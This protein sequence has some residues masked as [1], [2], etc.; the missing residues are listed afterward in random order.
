MLK[1]SG[2]QQWPGINAIDHRAGLLCS[3]AAENGASGREDIGVAP[4]EPRSLSAQACVGR[5]VVVAA[6]SSGL[7]AAAPSPI[8]TASGAEAWDGPCEFDDWAISAA[9]LLWRSARHPCPH[10]WSELKV[11]DYPTVSRHSVISARPTASRTSPVTVEDGSGMDESVISDVVG[12]DASGDDAPSVSDVVGVLP[13]PLSA[14]CHQHNVTTAKAHHQHRR[15]PAHQPA[16]PRVR[17]SVD[18][19]VVQVGGGTC[20]FTPRGPATGCFALAA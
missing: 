15:D 9:Q 16:A 7:L 4:V 13:G 18:R 1:Q 14:R 20:T 8:G 19:T 10:S 6:L 2:A 12:A 11:R 5:L 3:A 17:L